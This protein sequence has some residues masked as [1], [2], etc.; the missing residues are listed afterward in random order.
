MIQIGD[1]LPDIP[2]SWNMCRPRRRLQHW[3][4]PGQVAQA[5]AGKTIA[6]FAVPGAF[7]P[8]CSAQHVPCHVRNAAQPRPLKVDEIWVCR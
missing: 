2:P 7:T 1:S 8:T 3:P 5:C 4:A 6:L